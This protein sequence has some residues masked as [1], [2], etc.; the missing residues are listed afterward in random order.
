MIRRPPRSTRTDTRFP[1]T[2]LFRS[3]FEG[4]IS[5]EPAYQIAKASVIQLPTYGARHVPYVGTITLEQFPGW[6]SALAQTSAATLYNTIN[7]AAAA[8]PI[9]VHAL[10]GGVKIGRAHA[11]LQSLMRISYAV[12]CLKNKNN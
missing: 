8:S 10:R 3:K 6:R 2:T 11:E 5:R 7:A 9:T 1:Y 4:S 12:F